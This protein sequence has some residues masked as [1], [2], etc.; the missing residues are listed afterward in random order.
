MRERERERERRESEREGE[1]RKERF[2]NTFF[3]LSLGVKREY[4]DLTNVTDVDQVLPGFQCS[5]ICCGAFGYIDV[6]SKS[7]EV[8]GV[9]CIFHGNIEWWCKMVSIFDV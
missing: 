5:Q 8:G 7:G 1:K 2:Q 6:T 9:T 3:P 4:V